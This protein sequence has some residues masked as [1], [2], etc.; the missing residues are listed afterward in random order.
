MDRRERLARA[1]LMYLFTP[2]SPGAPGAPGAGDELDILEA[3]LPWIDVVQVR[4]KAPPGDTFGDPTEARATLDWTV[5]VLERVHAA[6]AEQVLVLVND[7]VDVARTLSDAGCD[8]VH[9]G[10]TDAPPA[11]AREVLGP[12]A[13]IG[14]STHDARQV[15]RA[16]EEPLDYL[17][18]GPIHATATKGYERG[19]GTERAWLAAEA[20][21]LPV[22][23]IGGIHEGN[24]QEL[25][26]VERAA[27][28]AAIAH[29]TDPAGT[30]R[31]LRAALESV[32]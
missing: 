24:A 23:A 3:A 17:G 29:S 25:D 15:V 11:L 13:L 8:G 5:R 4:V 32:G 10:Q 12:D 22:F 20:S 6:G 2:R 16:N 30:A 31:A 21:A 28:S 9:L 18:F 19:L 14:L 27:V 26:R 7:R 1:R